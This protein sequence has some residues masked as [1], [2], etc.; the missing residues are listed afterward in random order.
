GVFVR[1]EAERDSRYPEL[2]GRSQPGHGLVCVP[3]IGERGAL[4]GLVFSFPTDQDFPPERRA[5]KIALARQ[6]AVAP[7]RA[8]FSAPARA[9]GE[10]LSFLAEAT[11]L[12]TSSLEL[13]RTLE[14]LADLA[15]PQLADW[16]SISM[17]V[18]ETG[19]IEQLVVAHQ[20]PE[21]KRWAEA[22]RGRTR[23][24]QID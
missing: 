12:L 8:R 23:P 2:V 4:G 14:Q 11:A 13:E 21:R 18:E 20:D 1:S 19:D 17:L 5:L 6:A 10:R 22:M 9:L 3:L 16:C 7:Q 15:V 24:I